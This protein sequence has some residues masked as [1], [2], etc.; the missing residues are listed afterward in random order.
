MSVH[1]SPPSS[2]PTGSDCDSEPCLSNIPNRDLRINFSQAR[3]KRKRECTCEDKIQTVL[4]EMKA[5][6]T[7]FNANQDA[8]FNNLQSNI[9]AILDQH[10]SFRDSIDFI[11]K[12][13]DDLKDKID[14]LETERR[15]NHE[16]IHSLE[17]KIEN[18]ERNLL[19]TSLEFRSIPMKP[20]ETKEDL[21]SLIKTTGNAL[22]IPINCSDIK[23]VYRLPSKKPNTIRPIIVDFT[24]TILKDKILN[25]TKTLN[26]QRSTRLTTSVLKIDSSATPVYISESVTPK[27]KR[28]HFLARE[29]ASARK[30]DYCWITN[31]KIYLRKKEGAN[32]VR[33]QTESDLRKLEENE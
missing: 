12:Q 23:N 15:S 10:K 21:I 24:S 27:T 28:L 13:Y 19:V 6:M 29:F 8:K 5:L 9:N 7:Q 4:V 33:I 3:L 32:L 11:S 2:K 25:A 31:G 16:Y 22:N 18:L 20:K 14:T 30:Y 17:T 26:K 1:H